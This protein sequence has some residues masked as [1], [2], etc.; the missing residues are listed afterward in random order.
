MSGWLVYTLKGHKKQGTRLKAK[1]FKCKRFYTLDKVFGSS[2]LCK[3]RVRLSG[4]GALER[5]VIRA[6]LEII[7]AFLAA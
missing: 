4:P 5:G 1:V 6:D 7:L 2:P 3:N